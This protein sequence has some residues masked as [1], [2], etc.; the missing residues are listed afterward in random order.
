[1]HHE[2]AE[3]L[4]AELEIV[5]LELIDV[6]KLYNEEVDEHA[7]TL[8]REEFYGWLADHRGER[9]KKSRAR[10]TEL[11]EEIGLI[12]MAARKRDRWIGVALAVAA[13]LGGYVGFLFGCA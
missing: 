9:T 10:I 11:H 12:H 3:T 5:E 6:R 4:A 8:R 7:A 2:N 1:M 13:A